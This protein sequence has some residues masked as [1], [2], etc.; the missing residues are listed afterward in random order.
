[1]AQPLPLADALARVVRALHLGGG[2]LAVGDD[3]DVIISNTVISLKDP[4][5]GVR[6][7]TPAR[8]TDTEGLTA[9]DLDP[10]LET[11]QRTR[12][13]QDPHSMKH[14][15]VQRLQVRGQG[16]LWL[17]CPCTV[18]RVNGCHM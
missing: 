10:F 7:A 3:D 1:M 15:S 12:K 8:F 16:R 9:F 18:G 2:G 14:S 13:W 11:A 17:A 5:T 6:M 4:L